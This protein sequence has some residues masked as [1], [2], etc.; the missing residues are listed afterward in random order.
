MNV[1][2][3]PTGDPAHGGQVDRENGDFDCTIVKR[4]LALV[5]KHGGYLSVNPALQ[6]WWAEKNKRMVRGEDGQWSELPPES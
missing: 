5:N 4:S 2:V 1:H 3:S 6:S